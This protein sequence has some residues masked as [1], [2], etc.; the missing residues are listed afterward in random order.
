M[1][2][3]RHEFQQPLYGDVNVL[4]IGDVL[5][6]TG[7]V[8]PVSRDAVEAAL[9]GPLAG[10]ET[11]VHT[12]P[13]IDH[14]G[15]SQTIGALSDLPHV[16]P[17]GE[18]DILYD[19]ADYLRRAREEMMRLLGGFETTEDMWDLYFPLE[20]YAEERIDVV[21]ELSDGDI[22]EIGGYE[23]EAVSTTGHADPHLA[24]WHEPSGTMLSGDLVDRDGLF[25]YGPLLGDVGEYK[26]SL[27]RIRELEPKVLVPMHGPPMENPRER[28]DA[29]LE[30]AERTESRLLS[31]AEERGPFYAREFVEEEL[32]IA[33]TRSP[34]VTLVVYEYLEH[35]AERELLS[36]DI[37][38]EG[39]RVD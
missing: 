21:R 3:E 20:E 18:L 28:I 11:V 24:F 27:R 30:N 17:A 35:L 32:G 6:D 4:R 37:T 25:Q 15:G 7:H 2:Y 9:D 39:I 29:S 5:V 13:H 1:E 16:V 23:L 8:A 33:G 12:H 22:L 36:V 31:F 10:V 19:Y 26:A 34:F 38:D 14:V